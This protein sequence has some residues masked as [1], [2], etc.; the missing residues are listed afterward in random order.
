[1]SNN[2][3]LIGFMGS[4]KTS[5]GRILAKAINS[6]L[7]DVDMLIQSNLKMSINDIFSVFGEKYFR[8]YERYLCS[9]IKNNI[10]SAVISTGGGTPCI[11]DVKTLG[12]VVYLDSTLD[13]VI[14][15]VGN[16]ENRPKFSGDIHKLYNSRIDVYK[17][18]AD[19][20]V[21][22]KNGLDNVVQEILIKLNAKGITNV[23]TS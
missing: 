3:V 1:M 12:V 22:S 19:I 18:A 5:I 2:I 10:K 8:E 14:N 16:G 7:I 9:F 17:N 11:F 21:E 4:G 15:R 6:I 20:V 13:D 23:C